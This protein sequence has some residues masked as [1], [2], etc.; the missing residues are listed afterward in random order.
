LTFHLIYNKKR[1]N[2]TLRDRKIKNQKIFGERAKNGGV[3]GVLI[4]PE[5]FCPLA[6]KITKTIYKPLSKCY[7]INQYQV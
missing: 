6:E 7:D 4:S 5:I 3:S 1:K 2:T